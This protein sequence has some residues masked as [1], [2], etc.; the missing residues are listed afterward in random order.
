MFRSNCTITMRAPEL[1]GRM[2][3]AVLWITPK[4]PLLFLLS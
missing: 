2:V 4:E 3:D 1:S